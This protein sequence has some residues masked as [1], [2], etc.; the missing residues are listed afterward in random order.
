MLIIQ[1][2]KYD[3]NEAGRCLQSS[4]LPNKVPP[5]E[6]NNFTIYIMGILPLIKNTQYQIYLLRSILKMFYPSAKFKKYLAD[7]E[8]LLHCSA[9]TSEAEIYAFQTV[10]TVLHPI[11]AL[12]TD[13][14][15]QFRVMYHSVGNWQELFPLLAEGESELIREIMGQE[16][17]GAKP[18][19]I[20]H[21][22]K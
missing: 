11:N 7:Y 4:P 9:N 14:Y 21:V 1:I 2:T 20:Y 15:K 6:K 10:Q 22:K 5:F 19:K 3:S 18:R 13:T 17:V 16:M 12:G 8:S